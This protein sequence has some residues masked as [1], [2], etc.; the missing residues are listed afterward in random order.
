LAAAARSTLIAAAA[1]VYVAAID[2]QASQQVTDW[3]E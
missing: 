3:G 1:T 2:F